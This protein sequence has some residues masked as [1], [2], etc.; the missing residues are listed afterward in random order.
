MQDL[1]MVR[2]PASV[3]PNMQNGVRPLPPSVAHSTHACGSQVYLKSWGG[4]VHGVPPTGGG[5]GTGVVRN[6]TARG[7]TLDR[8]VSPV[9]LYQTN[10]AKSGDAPSV[11]QF[12]GLTF[13]NWSGTSTTSKSAGLPFA[14][15]ECADDTGGSCGH[16]MQRSG[17]V[18]RHPVQ[19]LRCAGGER[20]R[21]ELYLQER[22]VRVGPER[23]VLL[24]LERVCVLTSLDQPHAIRPVARERI[25]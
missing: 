22:A 8:V 14:W 10:G 21:A 4:T 1:S 6:V 13:E 12:S 3:Q 15:R 20:K 5:G 25:S 23:S 17:A 7:V 11:L 18:P 19:Q 24:M 2:L 16:R 9:H